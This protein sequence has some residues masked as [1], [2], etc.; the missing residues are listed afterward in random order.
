MTSR[1][2]SWY[3]LA[4][5]DPVP[6]DPAAV[7][8]DSA[9]HDAVAEHIANAA[10]GLRR[11][12]ADPQIQSKAAQAVRE[13]ANEVASSI[14]KARGRYVAVA[15]ALSQYAG[16]LRVAQRS[17]D[18]L[19]LRAREAQRVLDEAAQQRLRAVSLLTDLESE[20]SSDSSEV[21]AARARL[22]AARH[23]ADVAESQL[24]SLRYELEIVV[25]DRDMAAQHAIGRIDEATASDNLNDTWWE[26]GGLEIATEVSQIAG[27]VATIAGTAALVLGWV[28]ILG[29]ALALTATIAGAASLAANL[30]LAAKGEKGWTDAAF[31]VAGFVSFGWGRLLLKPLQRLG[32]QL[33]RAMQAVRSITRNSQARQFTNAKPI[34]AA[35]TNTRLPSGNLTVR[36]LVAA[37][38]RNA[39]ATYATAFRASLAQVTQGRNALL[40][41]AGNGDL[42]ADRQVLDRVQQFAPFPR[43]QDVVNPLLEKASKLEQQVVM[44]YGIDIATNAYGAAQMMTEAL[45]PRPQSARERLNL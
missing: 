34:A 11:L 40:A 44:I 26:D 29:P 24:A 15:E 19:L 28:P 5:T 22:E 36:D 39:P 4:A 31:D 12:A 6:G 10:A 21:R 16:E 27:K 14:Q 25:H 7:E 41:M 13:R 1:A 2:T 9:T 17:A 18:E 35:S 30:V 45:S 33:P 37:G 32:D 42:L 20:P 3:P 8:R 38:W 23:E 43:A